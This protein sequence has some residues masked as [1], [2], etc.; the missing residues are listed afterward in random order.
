MSRRGLAV[1]VAGAAVLAGGYVLWTWKTPAERAA[2][3]I[4]ERTAQARGGLKAW[5]GV[6]ALSMSGNLDA[7][8]P[9]D[10]VKLAMAQ[11]R[12]KSELRA[13]ARAN[14]ARGRAA[15]GE[16]PVQLPFVMELER[17]RKSR[18][19]VVYQGQTAVQVYDGS[20]GWKLRPFLGRREVE[21][22]TEEEMRQ[23]SLQSDLDGLLIDCERKGSRVEL[24][25]VEP[26][27]G[28]EAFKLQVTLPDGQVRH[29]WVDKETYLDVKVDGS[30]KMDGRPRFVFTVF[31]DF[32]TVDGL[33]IPHVMETSVE[34]LNDSEKIRVERVAVNPPLDD[35]R[36]EKPDAAG[37]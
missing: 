31:R 34:G 18:V 10:P 2:V 1:I 5:R 13:E 6:R 32:R 14:L 28:R 19:E 16:A 11:L 35:S 12:T 30:R 36:F 9:R 25:G 22:F 23:A 17:P 4:V 33:V 20:H 7:G 37:A 29:V 26:V 24:M 27:E 3:P 21:P 15:A 8:R